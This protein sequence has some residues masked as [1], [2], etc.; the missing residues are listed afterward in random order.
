MAPENEK[1]WL[2]A[3]RSG[4]LPAMQALIAA[5]EAPA[6]LAACREQGSSSSGH[7][8]L[9]WAA[10]G[11]HL[12]AATWLLS[13]A[14]TDVLAVNHGGSTALHSAAAND[15]AA[16]VELLLEHGVEAA[17]VKDANGDTP[18]GVAALREHE[19]A[20]RLLAHTAR[21]HAYL[22]LSLGGTGPLGLLL[23][24]LDTAAAPKA[25]ANFLGFASGAGGM[26]YRGTVF[27]RLLPGQ[28]LQGGQFKGG[29]FKGSIFGAPFADE[30]AGLGVRQDRRGLLCMANSGPNSNGSQFYLTLAPCEHLSGSHVV[31]GM[32]VPPH[33][34]TV[35]PRR[36]PAEQPRTKPAHPSAG[37]LSGGL[38][39]RQA[40]PRAAP[41]CRPA[42]ANQ[43]LGPALARDTGLASEPGRGRRGARGG[44]LRPCRRRRPADAAHLDQRVRPMAASASDGRRR[45]GARAERLPG[46]GRA[47]GQRQDRAGAPGT[48]AQLP[49]RPCLHRHLRPSP[50][51]GPEST[52]VLSAVAQGLKRARDAEGAEATP[53]GASGQA[54]AP[55]AAS[56]MARWEAIPGLS[57]GDSDEDD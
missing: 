44:G 4:D 1:Q 25:V 37:A 17:S 2:A 15:R 43:P 23:F 34:L 14:G 30:R 35:P 55:A 48:R 40:V 47:G 8:A 38:S 42:A 24:E 18:F 5:S 22:R 21:P 10:A 27:H 13:L 28:T 7:S 57:D 16:L 9:H 29:Q 56:K 26:C 36:S 3:S 49:R 19:A 39:Q 31:F 54:A 11:G 20:A 12:E 53:A 51:P 46:R 45:V 50:K 52:Q 32:L 6:E 33:V 41:G